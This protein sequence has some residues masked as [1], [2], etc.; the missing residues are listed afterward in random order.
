MR[1]QVSLLVVDK[2]DNFKVLYRGLREF[3]A[4]DHPNYSL[5]TAVDQV[6]GAMVQDAVDEIEESQ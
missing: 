3:D 4:I 2:G 6:A 5:A 1:Y